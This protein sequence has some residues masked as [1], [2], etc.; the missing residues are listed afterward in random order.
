MKRRSGKTGQKQWN[1]GTRELGKQSSGKSAEKAG[2][3]RSARKAG[4]RQNCSGGLRKA[5]PEPAEKSMSRVVTG[6]S[7]ADRCGRIGRSG[8]YADR[9]AVKRQKQKA[10]EVTEDE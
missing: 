4:L 7:G 9:I 1:Q 3:G 2:P 6:F 10:W 8:E 5:G